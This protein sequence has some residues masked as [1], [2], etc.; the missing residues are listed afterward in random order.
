MNTENNQTSTDHSNVESMSLSNFN[1]MLEATSTYM[2][3]DFYAD[4]CQ[5]CKRMEPILDSLSVDTE[6]YPNVQ[7]FKVDTEFEQELSEKFR[8][9]SIPA[10]HLIK[11]KADKSYEIVNS[12]IGSRDAFNFKMEILKSVADY[13]AKK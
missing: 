9:R 12:F 2:L 6:L 5:P 8:I 13:E 10:F 7:F 1:K 3:L 4:W 11:T